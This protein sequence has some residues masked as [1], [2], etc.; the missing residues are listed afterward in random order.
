M[1]ERIKT[2]GE[3]SSDIA[4]TIT[5][6]GGLY[7]E[8]VIT[9]KFYE[10]LFH[11]AVEHFSHLTR[12]AIERFYYQTGRTLKF[13][14]VNGE[15]LGGFACVGNE[16]IDFIGINFGSI[17][18]VSAIFTRML[19]N[20]NVLAFIGDANL[21]SNAGHTHFIPP[22]EDLNNFSPCKPA[23]PVRCAFSKHLT[24]TGLD[25][26][27][28]HEI[29]HITNGHLGIINRTESKDPDNCREKLT[30]LENQAIELDADHGATEWVLLFSEFVRKMRVKLPV[31]GY[32]SVGISWRNFY[33]D[34]PVTIA[35]TFFASYMLLRMTN[36]ESWDPEHQ[37]KAFQPKPPLRMGSLLRAYYFV[38]TEYH[39]L[40]PKETMSHLKDWY[41]ASEK[42][43][44]D[45]LAESGK[46]ET[47]EKEIES[48]F[49]EVCQYYDKVNEAYDTLAKELSEFAMVETAKVTHPRPR[50][51]DYVVL[52]GLKHGAE[53]I[54]IL[55]AKHSETSDK[56]LDLQCF[57]MDRRLPTGLPFTLNFV[58]EF[59]GDMID[60]AL[61]ADGKKHV[62]LIE[63]VTGLE[64]VELSSIS[65]KT[66]LLHFTLQY[67]ECFKLKEDLITLLEA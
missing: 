23:C 30:Q 33:V 32:D 7:D 62:A 64:A 67:S 5:A 28:G 51:C 35:Y 27:F 40:S 59:E 58:P 26:I 10:H 31:E 8:S 47:Q 3:V 25:F 39:Y 21:E 55:E 11:N 57:F 17:S 12:M 36:L 9:D 22:W 24:L 63:E 42:A 41:N 18:M 60:E 54:G 19:T 49:N 14:F 53:F 56:R 45:I 13:G 48:Y 38:L 66:D 44:G 46:G 65:D 37:L 50:T 2:L 52:K 6:R 15:R 20:P 34:E 1:T 29:A 16:N 61:T 4:T 43:L